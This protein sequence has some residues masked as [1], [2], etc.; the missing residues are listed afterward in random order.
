[1]QTIRYCHVKMLS[2]CSVEIHEQWHV[3]PNRCQINVRKIHE[4]IIFLMFKI[5]TFGGSC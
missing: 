1:M 2:K 5:M 4:V 3:I